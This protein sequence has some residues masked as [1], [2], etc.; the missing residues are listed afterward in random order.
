MK[1]GRF[2]FHSCMP[3]SLQMARFYN[4]ADLLERDVLVLGFSSL[5]ALVLG[6]VMVRRGMAK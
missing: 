4:S 1:E 5:A 3:R 6:T 2:E